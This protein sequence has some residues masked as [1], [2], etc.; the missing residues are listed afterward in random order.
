[1]FPR[2]CT[3]GGNGYVGRWSVSSRVGRRKDRPSYVSSLNRHRGKGQQ[4]VTH[5]YFLVGFRNDLVVMLNWAWNFVTFQRG[6]RLITGIV[7]AQMKDLKPTP[8]AGSPRDPA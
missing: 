1:M 4:K 7:G 6:S 3:G 8:Q 5:I 2:L